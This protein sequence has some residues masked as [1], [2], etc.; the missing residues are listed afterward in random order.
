MD[1]I[2]PIGITGFKDYAKTNLNTYRG[3]RFRLKVGKN[4][5]SYSGGIIC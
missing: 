3:A 5:N 2:S 4:L 1:T